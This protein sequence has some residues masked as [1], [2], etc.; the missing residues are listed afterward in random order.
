[1]SQENKP[2]D[3]IEALLRKT[4]AADSE[5]FQGAPRSGGRFWEVRANS[6]KPFAARSGP[7]RCAG[8]FGRALA[9]GPDLS[10]AAFRVAGRGGIP[11]CAKARPGRPVAVPRSG[12]DLPRCGKTGEALLSF[13]EAQRL[14][15]N[16]PEIHAALARAWKARGEREEALAELRKAERFNPGTANSE[17]LLGIACADLNDVPAALDIWNDGSRWPRARVE[18]GHDRALRQTGGWPESEAANPVR[19]GGI[20][21]G[22]FRR[23]LAGRLRERLTENEVQTIINPL[24]STPEMKQWALETVA[25]ATNDLRRRDRCSTTYSPSCCWIAGPPIARRRRFSGRAASGASNSIRAER[26]IVR[27][28]GRDA[29][30][31]VGDASM[32]RSRTPSL[33][34]QR[35]EQCGALLAIELLAPLPRDRKTSCAVRSVVRRSSSNSASMWSNSDRAFARSL[36][37]PATVS[38]AHC[39]SRACSPVG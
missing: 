23:K 2:L 27:R 3:P 29:C 30:C 22:L 38:S 28:A 1:M 33:P 25:G 35:D 12:N 31:D 18:P 39:S 15:P 8:P 17:R 11:C 7:S 16:H 34:A 37:A 36:V 5:F 19:H 10:L 6:T 14:F 24:A 32:S 13:S 4:L 9:P 20:A 21:D 26:R